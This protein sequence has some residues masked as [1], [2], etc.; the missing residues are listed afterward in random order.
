MNLSDFFFFFISRK[1]R[2]SLPS[3]LEVY[4]TSLS[5]V[6]FLF[7]LVFLL[8]KDIVTYSFI[9]LLTNTMTMKIICNSNMCFWCMTNRVL[10]LFY[11]IRKEE[12]ILIYSKCDLIIPGILKDFTAFERPWDGLRKESLRFLW[13][14]L[15]N[16]LGWC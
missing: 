4:L 8:C 5:L 15:K 13:W 6:L 9:Y 12:I 14:Q 2:L 11:K 7:C 16:K 10:N 3:G 1:S